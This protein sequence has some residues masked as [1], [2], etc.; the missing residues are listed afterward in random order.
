MA[1]A[2]YGQGR[3]NTLLGLS[4]PFIAPVLLWRC[5]NM[6][7]HGC[8]P[9]SHRCVL[10]YGAIFV[11]PLGYCPGICRQFPSLFELL[12]MGS[13]PKLELRWNFGLVQLRRHAVATVRGI[14]QRQH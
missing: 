12:R 7:W 3:G 10:H 8:W 2:V 5:I 11:S 6:L 1:A 9:R 14:K 4:A 13:S